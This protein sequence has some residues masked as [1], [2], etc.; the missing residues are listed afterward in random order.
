ME[1]IVIFIAS[2]LMASTGQGI[3]FVIGVLAAFWYMIRT[4]PEQK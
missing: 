4:R 2:G 3:G 1:L